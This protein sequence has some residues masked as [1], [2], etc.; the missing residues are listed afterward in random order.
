MYDHDAALVIDGLNTSA[1]DDAQLARFRAGGVTAF[2]WTVAKPS[3]DWPAVLAGIENAHRRVEA[4]EGRVILA[5]RAADVARAKAEGTVAAI[6]GLQNA[7]SIGDDLSRARTLHRL[8]VRVVQLTY[9]ERNVFGDG[10]DEPADAGLSRL[11]QRLVGELNDAGVLVDLSHC[12][13][14]TTLDALRLSS[15]AAAMTH[16]N[17]RRLCPTPRNKSDEEIRAAAGAGGIVGLAFWAPLSGAASRPTIETMLDHADALRRI[18]GD[19]LPSIGSDL[20]EGV[21][22]AAIEWERNLVTSEHLYPDVTKHVGAWYRFETRYP[23]GLESVARLRDFGAR[24][25]ERGWPASAIANLMGG[26]FL[27]VFAAACG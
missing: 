2:Q 25:S 6:F 21:Y 10:C 4:M 16:A 20:T 12:G 3:G 24:L 18:G 27:R 8:G 1:L 9:N 26:N 7:A 22:R 23:E 15:P 13:R 11:G 5:R 19:T 17:V 14:A